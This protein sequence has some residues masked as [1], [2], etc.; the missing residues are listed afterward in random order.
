MFICWVIYIKNVLLHYVN[1]APESCPSVVAERTCLHC[2]RWLSPV[3]QPADPV[4]VLVW[5]LVF[6]GV[7]LPGT[8]NLHVL[9]LSGST[10]APSCSRLWVRGLQSPPS[11]ESLLFSPP[12]LRLLSV[13]LPVTPYRGSL[14]FPLICT[15]APRA[16]AWLRPLFCGVW[17]RV[18]EQTLVSLSL[19]QPSC[20]AAA[21][22]MKPV[23]Q[24][25]LRFNERTPLGNC[26][27]H[28]YI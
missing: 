24:V 9:C 11:S 25:K 21:V 19:S 26:D 6:A 18:A 13:Y 5:F 27:V 28:T 22:L 12:L 1:I 7:F 14:F 16:H 17:M 2:P 4:C 8:E 3:L 20:R 10:S 23:V 15:L